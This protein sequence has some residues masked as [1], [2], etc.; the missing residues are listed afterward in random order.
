MNFK[1]KGIVCPL[2]AT[3][4]FTGSLLPENLNL[5]RWNQLQQLEELKCTEGELH[6]RLLHFH[7]IT[8][9]YY[10][11]LI[12]DGIASGYPRLLSH[13]WAGLPSNIDAATA[14][15]EG[16]TYFFKGNRYWTYYHTSP[17]VCNPLYISVGWPGI[18]DNADG[19]MWGGG[20][21]FYFFKGEFIIY[22]LWQLV[23]RRQR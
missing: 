8:G 4:M 1:L 7:I 22:S 10:W 17:H 9:E 15:S 5:R 20:S 3:S 14:T 21:D 19:A 13:R 2:L 11:K 16:L 18:P 23:T 12:A 6:N